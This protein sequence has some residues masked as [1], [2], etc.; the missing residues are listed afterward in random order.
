LFVAEKEVETGKFNK[1]FNFIILLP[2]KKKE[3]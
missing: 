1:I 2:R 3:K